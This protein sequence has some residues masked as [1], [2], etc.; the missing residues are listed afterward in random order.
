M[1]VNK[2]FVLSKMSVKNVGEKMLCFFLKELPPYCL[3]GFDLTTHTS[4]WSQAR[5]HLH[6]IA[7]QI[8]Y[9]VS[10][11]KVLEIP[12]ESWEQLMNWFWALM[13]TP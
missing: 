2:C 12:V 7:S 13:A 3:A 10:T 1:S 4:A 8:A 9:C 11:T 6:P 5:P